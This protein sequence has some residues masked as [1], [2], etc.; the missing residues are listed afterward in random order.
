MDAEACINSNGNNNSR[1]GQHCG[2]N[3]IQINLID[4]SVLI[5]HSLARVYLYVFVYMHGHVILTPTN[6]GGHHKIGDRYFSDK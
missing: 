3:N 4:T 2:T 6:D 5:V 1:N